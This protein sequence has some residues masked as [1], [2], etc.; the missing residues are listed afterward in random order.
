VAEHTTTKHWCNLLSD[1][2]TEWLLGHA[3]ANGSDV[4]EQHVRKRALDV[5]V[6]PITTWK[7]ALASGARRFAYQVGQ[8]C[9]LSRHVGGK[10][11]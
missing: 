6:R 2:G 7:R 9:I 4:A 1:R 5:V 10:P 8:R 3:T 11:Q